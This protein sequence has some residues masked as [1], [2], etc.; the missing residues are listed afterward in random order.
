MPLTAQILLLMFGLAIGGGMTLIGAMCVAE[1]AFEDN[2]EL[3]GFAMIAGTII[4]A[5]GLILFLVAAVSLAA[6]VL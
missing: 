6:T 1:G 5:F 2:A 3:R 4:G